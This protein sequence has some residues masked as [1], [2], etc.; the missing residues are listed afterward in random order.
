MGEGCCRVSDTSP[1]EY[2]RKWWTYA[3]NE[4]GVFK[5]QRSWAPNTGWCG[6]GSSSTVRDQGAV[7]NKNT[8]EQ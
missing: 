7:I 1:L 4:S 3:V 2:S 6:A 5:H 8:T